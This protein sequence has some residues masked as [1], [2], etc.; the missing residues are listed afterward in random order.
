MPIHKTASGKWKWGKSGKEYD[1][2][3][4]AEKQ[5]RAIFAS[6]YKEETEFPTFRKYLNCKRN[7]N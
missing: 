1:K 5:M 3:E 7:E 2:K 6:G 4:D